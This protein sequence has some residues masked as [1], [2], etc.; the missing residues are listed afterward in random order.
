MKNLRHM[1]KTILFILILF[2]EFAIAQETVGLVYSDINETKADGYTLFNTLSDDRVYLINNC[3]EVV[4]QW[5]FS[6]KNSKQ[7]YLL[8][9]GNLWQSDQETADIRDWD[10]NVI[11][12]VEFNSLGF[13]IHHDIAPLP[14][15]NFLLLIRDTYTDVEMLAQ[16]KDT[17]FDGSRFVLDKIIEIEPV[18]TNSANIVWEWKFFDHLIQQFDSSKPNF[19][20]IS[21]NPQLLDMNYEAFNSVDYTHGNGIDYNADLDQIMISARHT[22]EIY[23]I[24]H[25]TTTAQAASNSGGIYGKGGDFLWRWGNPAVYDSGTAANQT[26][27]KQHDA[28]W[29]TDGIHKGK[30]S[31]FSN[32]AYGTDLSASSAHIIE[33]NDVDG[34]YNLD[35]G[36]F[37]P[38]DYFW[39]YNG[40]ILGEILRENSRSGV[41]IMPNGNALINETNKGRISEVDS[42]GKVIWVYKIPISGGTTFDQYTKEIAD[43]GS[44]RATRY[45]EN[46]VGFDGLTIVSSGIIENENSI[47][48]NCAKLLSVDN[49]YFSDLRVYPNPTKDWLNFNFNKPIDQIKVYDIYGKIVLTQTNAE[50]V[51]LES[52]ANG[53]YVVKILSGG[54]TDSLKI[55]KN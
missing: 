42:S 6:G 47:S 9:N 11:W 18:G 26:L 10:N 33:P 53:L 3:G 1:K 20:S 7:S 55:I 28:K 21:A 24:D 17:S 37:S 44:F 35:K 8:E 27:G 25:S 5:D 43:N 12:S 52:L 19:G 13:R 16:G 49:L 54:S 2:C 32:D 34:V 31:V 38:E 23:V 45:P 51:N 4:N 39:S 41:Q 30:I 48:A 36:K 14:N 50:L 46:Y 15:G 40:T 29:I 22:S